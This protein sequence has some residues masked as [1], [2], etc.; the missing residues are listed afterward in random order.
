MQQVNSYLIRSVRDMLRWSTLRFAL[1]L[2]L[3]LMGLWIWIGIQ[4]WGYA[5]AFASAIINWI[6]FSIVKANG[7]LFIIF[8]LWF[9]LVLV[10]FAAITALVGPPI[11]RYFKEKTYYIYT[12]TSLMLLAAFWSGFILVKW[13]WIFGEVQELLTYLPFQTVSDAYAW[14]I[15]FYF[16]Y[17]AFILTLFILISVIRKHF[18]EPIRLKEYPDVAIPERRVKKFYKSRALWDVVLFMIF[19]VVALPIFFIP[20]ANIVVQLWLWAWLY[21]ESYFQSTCTLY[22]TEKD[23]EAL[24]H[25]R[26]MNWSIAMTA[27]MLNFLPVINIFAPFFGQL[28]FF[29]WIMEE[30]QKGELTPSAP[31]GDTSPTASPEEETEDEED[32]EDEEDFPMPSEESQEQG[33]IR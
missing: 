15:A 14:L 23:Y 1:F 4:T 27:A 33:E 30:R 7:A 22:C 19:T 31:Q 21:R 28:M 29:H 16:Y 26:L 12:F 24:K 8:F 10:S 5:M 20:M 32:E 25:H 17:N 13:E 3:P 2:G 6:P 18:L 9:I 11:L